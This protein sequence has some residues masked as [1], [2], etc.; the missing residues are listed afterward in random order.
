M[1]ADLRLT[2][3]EQRCVGRSQKDRVLAAL[4]AGRRISPLDALRLFGT[5][6]LAARISELRQEGHPIETE[7]CQ[8]H[9]VYF[10]SRRRA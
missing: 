10:L 1:T 6:R 4:Q 5:F 2:Q 8:G 7:S 9:A 3:T